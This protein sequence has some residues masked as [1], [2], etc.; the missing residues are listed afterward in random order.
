MDYIHLNI[1]QLRERKKLTQQQFSEL[2]GISRA[3]LASYES[4]VVPTEKALKKIADAAGVDISEL[5]SP[6]HY[7]NFNKFERDAVRKF[8]D[9]DI[10]RRVA[11]ILNRNPMP[12]TDS[13]VA[14][15]PDTIEALQYQVEYLSDQLASF[16][17][18]LE[19]A[20]ELITE[21]RENNSF[22]KSL[23]PKQ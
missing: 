9:A 16:K 11:L 21:L 19:R 13:N 3:S 18:K 7:K 14:P 6:V 10:N 8:V 20:D 12:A 17:S 5:K 4:N 15:I 1:R 2:A 23:L 22:I